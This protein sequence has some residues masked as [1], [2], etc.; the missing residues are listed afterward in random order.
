[1][2]TSNVYVYDTFLIVLNI[3]VF[4]MIAVGF[5]TVFNNYSDILTNWYAK[6]IIDTNANLGVIEA[7]KYVIVVIVAIF[8]SLNSLIGIKIT[9]EKNKFIFEN[10]L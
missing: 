4:V 7:F 8:I 10:H 3:F 6:D 1:M 9:Y 5:F 2:N